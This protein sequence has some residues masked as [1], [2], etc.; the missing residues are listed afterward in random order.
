MVSQMP[1]PVVDGKLRDEPIQLHP[2]SR[3]NEIFSQLHVVIYRIPPRN[4]SRLYQ[5][6]RLPFCDAGGVLPV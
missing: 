3:E 5:H 2:T 1:C 4:T 6:S